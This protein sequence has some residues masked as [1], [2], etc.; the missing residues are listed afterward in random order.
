MLG[1]TVP[2]VELWDEAREEFVSTST[3]VLLLEHSL[4][5]LSKWES[6]TEKPF[7]GDDA[8]TRDET[9]EYIKCMTIAPVSSPNV[10]NNLTSDNFKEI[11]KYIDRKMTATTFTEIAGSHKNSEFITSEII[12]YWMVALTIPFEC[13]Y[14][15]LSKLLAL[16]RVL[17]IK[18]NP[19]K[20]MGRREMLTQR[21]S[22]NEQR[23]AQMNSKG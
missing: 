6:I 11:S 14:W 16:I 2:G 12:Y 17:N 15:H 9:I 8:K 1:V 3:E 21:R 23:K 22:L 13:Q 19:P 20:K 4:I 18:N 5:S 10:F 7:L